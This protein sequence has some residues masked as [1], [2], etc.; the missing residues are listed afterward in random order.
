M[1]PKRASTVWTG[2][3]R[4]GDPNVPGTKLPHWPAYDA[5]TRATMMFD[6]KSRIENDPMGDIRRI[7][8]S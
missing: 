8:L 6:L 3:A 7:S 1:P 5:E 2:F 4:T